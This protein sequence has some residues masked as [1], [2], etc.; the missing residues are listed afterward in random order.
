MSVMLR[1]WKAC[2]VDAACD[3]VTSAGVAATLLSESEAARM[4]TL[5]VPAFSDPASDAVVVMFSRSM[6]TE[7]A[8]P[9]EPP[10]APDFADAP[11]VCVECI[12]AWI[13]A[14][15]EVT[16]FPPGRMAVLTMS[17]LLIATAMPMLTP[18]PPDGVTA[19]PSARANASVFADVPSV[20]RPPAFTVIGPASVARDQ[21]FARFTATAAATLTPPDEVDAAGVLSAPSVAPPPLLDRVVFA[22]PRCSF[23]CW[24]TPLELG[25][26]GAALGE[27]SAGAPDAD[28][29]ALA[30]LSDDPSALSDTAP[31][32][33]RSRASHAS[34]R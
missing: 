27:E 23:T 14:P 30:E 17:T 34:L 8:I 18:P 3:N 24:V 22:K 31:T 13:V 25:S 28:A 9:T 10:P 33:V 16:V 21:L 1:T 20:N 32:A 11:S 2:G 19:V 29:V 6:A 5:P 26:A 4:I 12:S 7:P 15:C